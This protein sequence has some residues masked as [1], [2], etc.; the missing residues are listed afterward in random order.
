MSKG[1]LGLGDSYTWGEGLYFYSDLDNLPFSENHCFEDSEV[2]SA[3]RLYKDRHKYLALVANYLDT[4]FWNDEGNGGSQYSQI[5]Y[6]RNHLTRKDGFN[7]SDFKLVIFQF[8]QFQR[9]IEKY[10]KTDIDLALQYQ[11][12]DVDKL[13]KEFESLGIPTITI[14]WCRFISEHPL[15]QKLFEKRHTDITYNGE[16]YSSFAP[17]VWNDYHGLTVKSDF[18]EKGLQKNDEHFNKK[19]NRV[20]ADSIISKIEKLRIE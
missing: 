9:D 15:Y 8:T 16:S 18:A 12:E 11:I 17:L 4:W 14:S 2:T 20:I 3:M 19:G 5:D 13:L 10:H 6:V 7:Y 1:V